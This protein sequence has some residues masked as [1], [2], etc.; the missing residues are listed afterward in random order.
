LGGG[1]YALRFEGRGAP[2]IVVWT[3]GSER[4]VELNVGAEKVRLVRLFGLEEELEAPGGVLKLR[5]SGSPVV[6]EPLG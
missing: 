5:V 4:G 6:A 1:A 2:K 3:D